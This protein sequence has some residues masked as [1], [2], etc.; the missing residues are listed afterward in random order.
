MSKM[1]DI[2]SLCKVLADERG[3][4]RK[5]LEAKLKAQNALDLEHNA[6]LR[7]LQE[8]CE[9][10]RQDLEQRL[11]SARDEFKSPKSK[12]FFGIIVGYRKGQTTLT[13]PEDSILIDR[14]EKMLPAKQAETILDRTVT[15]I[16]DAFKKL[17]AEV[18]QKL[19]CS[20]STGADDHFIRT[21]DDD[22]EAIVKKSLGN[23]AK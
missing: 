8:S 12:T 13:V 22:V 7:A 15:I 19:G 3:K 16:K 5:K 21:T 20:S 6:G 18:L 2:E 10:V 4:L 23:P 17:P 14:I 9:S 1:N 11:V